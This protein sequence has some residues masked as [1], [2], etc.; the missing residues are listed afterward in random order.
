[1]IKVFENEMNKLTPGESRPTLTD[2]RLLARNLPS[3]FS[4][5]SA[6][7]ADSSTKKKKAFEMITSMNSSYRV[8]FELF[9]I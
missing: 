7:S 5:K 3:C 9:G 8:R 4:A 2:E 6:R 1:M